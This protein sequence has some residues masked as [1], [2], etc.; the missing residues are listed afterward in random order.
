M[1]LGQCMMF[2]VGLINF[3]IQNLVY[4]IQWWLTEKIN[5]E[6]IMLCFE[7]RNIADVSCW[8]WHDNYKNK[9]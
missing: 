1:K 8:A 7:M 2:A 9:V 5:F 3:K 6:D 4:F